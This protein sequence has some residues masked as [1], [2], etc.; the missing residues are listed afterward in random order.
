MATSS[1]AGHA[2]ARRHGPL[3]EE[4]P[5]AGA[6]IASAVVQA[7]DRCDRR[8]ARES[9]ERVVGMDQP[10]RKSAA[11]EHLETPIPA[12]WALVTSEYAVQC[13]R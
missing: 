12:L 8:R 4:W 13:Q 7:H 3:G 11:N 2:S 10:R 6:R 5:S 9:W 1:P